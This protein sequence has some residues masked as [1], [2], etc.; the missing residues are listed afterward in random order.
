IDRQNESDV[1]LSVSG[2]L[3]SGQLRMSINFSK[4]IYQLNTIQ[5]LV[6]SYQRNLTN[7]IEELSIIKENYPT[8]SD[9]TFKGLS[10]EDLFVINR[11]N[12]LED[13][14]KLSPL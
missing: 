7:I 9:L 3:V 5:D 8:P 4:E 10:I 11:D 13:V 2:I 14:Y 12:T 1:A 6:D